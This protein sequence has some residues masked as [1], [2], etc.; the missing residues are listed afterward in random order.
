MITIT[1][2]TAD[3]HA[4]AAIIAYINSL[5]AHDPQRAATLSYAFFATA[6]PPALVIRP[7]DP[8]S[9]EALTL[10]TD[11]TPAERSAILHYAAII[12]RD[13]PQRA[14]ALRTQ[15]AAAIVGHDES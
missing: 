11:G 9:C 6:S 14:A 4:R 2:T 7:A 13:Q 15:V 5:H 3:E 12:D 8:V 1:L 10:H